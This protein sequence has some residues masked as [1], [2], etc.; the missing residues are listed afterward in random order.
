MKAIL[1]ALVLCLLISACGG[2]S[3]TGP[4][5]TTGPSSNTTTVP[6]NPNPNPNPTPAPTPAG[7]LGLSPENA[8][9]GV[10]QSMVF[11]ASGGDGW[12]YTMMASPFGVLQWDQISYNQIRVTLAQ[13]GGVN[14]GVINVISAYNGS[15]VERNFVVRFR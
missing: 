11:T 1:S 8:T 6:S 12:N 10:G 3:P 7:N 5:P 2:D 4:T 13:K 14:E 15:I 9:I